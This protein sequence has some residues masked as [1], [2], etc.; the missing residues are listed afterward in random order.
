[1]RTVA[2]ATVSALLDDGVLDCGPI[3]VIGGGA[4]GARR[5]G[6]EA[7]EPGIG[8]EPRVERVRSRRIGRRPLRADQLVDEDR[9][10]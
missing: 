2:A 6:A 9:R 5:G 7:E 8:R 1:M 4:K 3:G 10:G